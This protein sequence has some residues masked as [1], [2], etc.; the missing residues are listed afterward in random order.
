MSIKL[1]IGKL[2]FTEREL[3]TNEAIAALP[4]KDDAVATK[5]FLY[6]Y[7]SSLDWNDIAGNDEK[8]KGETLNKKN[9]NA[10]QVTFPPL[11]Q[12]QR[13]VAK[14]DAAFSEIDRAVNA[15]KSR[16]HELGILRETIV[17]TEMLRH[18]GAK[19]VV[20]RSLGDVC[21]LQ[22]GYGFKSKDYVDS[23]NTLNIRMS[24]IRPNGDFDANHNAR[25]LP[26]SYADG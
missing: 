17:A 6:H 22:N 20:T 26:D 5:E 25:F 10:T 18:A 2:A 15:T 16:S 3:C 7:L 14:L 23:S 11:P 19:D 13:I 8:V 21:D 4:I 1:S 12:Q 24:N 9:L